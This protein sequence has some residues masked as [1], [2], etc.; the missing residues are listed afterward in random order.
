MNGRKIVNLL[1]EGY[2]MPK[3]QHV[4]NKLYVIIALLWFFVSD[5]PS[6]TEVLVVVVFVLSL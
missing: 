3:P 5:G 2:R 4:N 6:R 1:Q